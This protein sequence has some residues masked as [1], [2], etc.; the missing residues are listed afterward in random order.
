LARLRREARE[1]DAVTSDPEYEPRYEPDVQRIYRNE[2]VEV[3]WSPS[4]CTHFR[5]CVRGAPEV[6]DARRRPWIDLDR[7]S[8]ERILEVVAECPTGAL[9]AR[10]LHGQPEDE[11]FELTAVYVQQDGPLFVRGRVRVI[12]AEGSIIREDVRLA[13]CRC[14]ASQNKPFCD[15]SHYRIGFKG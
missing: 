6:F 8:P 15:D 2:A 12:G 13:L 10:L 9:H 7:D 11:A 1:E 4:Y 5:A 3:T 14:G